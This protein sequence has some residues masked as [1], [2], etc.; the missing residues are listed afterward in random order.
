MKKKLKKI[1]EKAPET[2]RILWQEGFFMNWSDQE[3]VSA[4]L[5]ERGNHFRPNTLRMA[6]VRSPLLIS[7]KQNDSLEFIQKKP[8]VSKEVE[9]VENELFEDGLIEKLGKAFEI[10][11]ADLHHNFRKSGNCTAFLLRKMLEKLIYI[12]FAKNGL[13]SRLE[14]ANGS[15]RLVGLEAMINTAAREK[16]NGM[17]FITT[18]TAEAIRGIKFLGDASAHNPLTDVDMKTILHQ[19]PCIVM[20]YKELS[21]LL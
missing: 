21:R 2:L 8:A 16:V 7:R 10:E 20:A 3:D 9:K 4:H 19:I 17:P 13:G 15:G 6:L 11:I 5:A 12:T 1:A 18:H 14:V